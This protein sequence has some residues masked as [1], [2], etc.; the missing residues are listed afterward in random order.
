MGRGEQKTRPT[1]ETHEGTLKGRARPPRPPRGSRARSI[2]VYG[3]IGTLRKKRH[4]CPETD[5]SGDRTPPGDRTR[6][7][8]GRPLRV[9]HPS[10]LRRAGPHLRSATRKTPRSERTRGPGPSRAP[11]PAADLHAT[12]RAGPHLRSGAEGEANAPEGD[13]GGG[14]TAES[15]SRRSGQ[16]NPSPC[17]PRRAGPGRVPV[18]PSP[19]P[20]G[21]GEMLVD[22][23]RPP[24]SRDLERRDGHPPQKPTEP[25]SGDSRTSLGLGVPGT[26]TASVAG[27]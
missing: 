21:H 10:R 15:E 20:E 7:R 25:I 17:S 27:L 5:A 16:G 23:A 8:A 13:P 9:T 22:P 6:A 2:H 18:G 3:P 19:R 11:P 4:A 1:T 12:A 24:Q 26:V 14:R